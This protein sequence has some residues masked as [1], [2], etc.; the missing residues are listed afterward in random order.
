MRAGQQ[1]KRNLTVAVTKM[2]EAWSWVLALG[3]L[4]QL[5]LAG[6]KLRVAWVVGFGTSVLWAVF[7][8]T[9]GSFG[10]LLSAT[11]FGFVHVRNWIL[12]GPHESH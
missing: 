12:W 10:F 2:I 11:I 1:K 3:G 5:V 6:K 4:S 7:A 8:V 9:T